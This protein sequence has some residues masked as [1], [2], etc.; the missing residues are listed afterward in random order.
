M[1]T[2]VKTGW[3]K[4]SNGEKFAPK[5]L[6]SQVQTSD[7][8]LLEDKIQADLN[9]L[10]SE[11]KEATT[12]V[13]ALEPLIGT[14]TEVTPA[15]V[16]EA[17][18]AGR[19]ICIEDSDAN[20]TFTSAAIESGGVYMSEAVTVDG[21]TAIVSRMGD[22]DYWSDI[23]VMY[24]AP[25]DLNQNDPE[26]PDYV[27]GRTH[28]AETTTIM[29]P[30]S[31]PLSSGQ[32]DLPVAATDFVIGDTYRI[33][34]DGVNYDC[35]AIDGSVAHPAAAGWICMG[36]IGA[37][38]GTN[39]TGEPFI[40]VCTVNEGSQF[41]LIDDYGATSATIAIYRNTYHKLD[42]NFI[43][44]PDW[45]ASEGQPGHILNRTHW[46]DVVKGTVLMDNVTIPMTDGQAEVPTG[47]VV[48]LPGTTYLITFNGVEYKCTVRDGATIDPSGAGMVVA[49]NIEYALGIGD[50]GEPFVLAGADGM[51]TIMDVYDP[52]AT[53][54]TI[55]TQKITETIHKL[56]NMFVDAE[57]MA[58]E[59]VTKGAVILEGTSLTGVPA[60]TEVNAS[61]VCDYGTTYIATINGI[62]YQYKTNERNP[63]LNVEE[64]DIIFGN[65]A[66]ISSN[67][68][69]TGEP[70]LWIYRQF[71]WD[72]ASL[73]DTITVS[74]HE[75]T[76]TPNKLPAKFLPDDIGGGV[77]YVTIEYIDGAYTADATYAQI[78]EWIS[79]GMDVKVLYEKLIL[80]LNRSVSDLNT[81]MRAVE[82][83]NY[84]FST[85]CYNKN[86]VVVIDD[87]D[88]VDCYNERLA[89]YADIPTK[90]S[91]LTNDSSFITAEY[92]DTV[93]TNAANTVKNDLLNGAG[94]AYDTLKELG[95][96]IDENQ[97]A[98]EALEDIAIGKADKTEVDEIKKAKADWNQN[99]ETALD[100]IKNR[101]HYVKSNDDIIIFPEVTAEVDSNG[102]VGI[103]GD[104]YID[105]VGRRI[106][107]G[108]HYI[109]R[110]N[111]VD[112]DCVANPM[113]TEDSTTLEPYIVLGNANISE[114]I[115][116]NYKIKYSTND[117]FCFEFYDLFC[118]CD[119]SAPPEWGWTHFFSTSTSEDITSVTF[120][121][122]KANCDIKKL[123]NKFINAD[124]IGTSELVELI[125]ET[126]FTGTYRSSVCVN[127]ESNYG[128]LKSY[129]NTL[130]SGRWLTDIDDLM[131]TTLCVVFDGYEYYVDP[132][133][134]YSSNTIVN[135]AGYP[136]WGNASLVKST[137]TEFAISEESV[138]IP[139]ALA[140]SIN[141]PW[142][143]VTNENPHTVAVYAVRPKDKLPIH[144]IPDTIVRT[145]DIPTTLKN[146]NALTFTG[147]VTGDY[148]G[149]AAKTVNI[150]GK[151][152]TGTNAEMFNRASEAS[153]NAAHAEGIGTVAGGQ[154]AHAE[155]MHTITSNGSN[156]QHVQGKYN[157]SD[158]TSAHI[159][160]N[161]TADDARSNAHTIDWEGN[162]WFAGDVYVGSTS[163]TNK[164][165][166]SKKLATEEYVNI[167]VPA[168]TTAD[169]GAILRIVNGTPKWVMLPYAEEGSF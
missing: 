124:W 158:T 72:T 55:S 41:T 22:G 70:F 152:G 106:I 39:N 61:A 62:E 150:I 148:D 11:I 71:F 42:P 139:F 115:S 86:Y 164:D 132:V 6:T 111:G 140:N 145:N 89:L 92:A 17:I 153:G 14:T 29:Q 65:L 54:C 32:C 56:D 142:I 149:S 125:P 109:V 68:P 79:S 147:T 19:S 100:Y 120:S 122:H 91:D 95:A 157:I 74:I 8:T 40:I 165:N 135:L 81:L 97:D 119:V 134:N 80:S 12:A 121:V 102:I 31:I 103:N 50:T 51:M 137:N 116:D 59:T 99:D 44:T 98:I 155:G 90:T 69:N 108:E 15:Q 1:S 3:L 21:I 23:Q 67:L 161:G 104:W 117:P 60:S 16:L 163:G 133:Q 64:D 131:N 110:W 84:E 129:N 76:V 46:V 113:G 9:G 18:T 154:A 162:A 167:R 96:L 48:I 85:V 138:G 5:T 35:V 114:Y 83:N 168:W 13:A 77:K 136:V 156:C 130:T 53:S 66:F 38:L 123:D 151:A 33:V 57:W 20:I 49:G 28:W 34:Y 82:K 30:V 26:Q 37:A 63:D 7:G 143:Y 87:D 94:E 128:T 45:N 169:E 4:D 36:N 27:K 52:I 88:S 2:T 126:T 73:G 58:T 127:V 105:C 93:A 166:G 10:K 25:P 47:D 24:V 159:V 118:M 112:Y 75:A 146:P 43:H 78:T 141:V 107:P 101:T 144:F 160:G